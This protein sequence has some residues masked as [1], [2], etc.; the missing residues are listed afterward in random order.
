MKKIFKIYLYLILVLTIDLT[1]F[2]YIEEA[3]AASASF[4][5]SPSS[6]QVSV[7]E[8]ISASVM[9]STDVA[10]NAGEGSVSYPS[11]IL[12]YQS[13]SNSG[14]IFSFWTSGPSG[15]ESGVTFGG[16]LASPGYS[17]SGGRVLTITWKA[18]QNGTATI[19]ITGSKILAN[20]GT[21]TNILSGSSG[22]TVT[23]GGVAKTPSQAT[24]VSSSTH[25]DQNAWYKEKKVDLSW[26]AAA[27][28][29]YSFS[30]DQ[31]P[32][33]TPSVTPVSSKSKSYD[34][35]AE[36]VWYFHIRA[37]FD[38]GFGQTTH[39]KIQ[40]DTTPPEE[41]SISINQ[42]GGISNPT[43]AVNFAA[44]DKLSGI[45]RYEALID[46][47]QPFAITSGDKLPKQKPGDHTV[48]IRAI[49]K[50]G[51][52]RESNGIYHIQ[53]IGPPV[54]LD[55][56]KTVGLL[57]Y[58]TFSG[59]AVPDDTII[60]YLGDK[61]L[62]RFKAGDYKITDVS[63]SLFNIKVEAQ[64]NG[65]IVWQYSIEKALFAGTYYFRIG[66]IDKNGAESE[67]SN[68]LKV[69]VAASTIKLLGRS[70]PILYL[71]IPLVVIIIV[72]LVVIFWLLR[73]IRRF[74]KN[75]GV[76]FGPAWLRVKGVFSRTEVEIDNQ[77][78]EVIPGNN[79]SGGILNKIKNDLKEK[80]HETFQ[81]EE[82]QMNIREDP[83]AN[84]NKV[85]TN[86]LD[87]FS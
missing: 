66:R 20:D 22:G 40:I 45:A 57:E 5:L 16:G 12:E 43:P 64:S 23:V 37:N 52:I 18:K 58:I 14:S 56:S 25:P 32:S 78:E 19:N 67:L 9:V 4:F 7:G 83:K 84:A 29:G 38:S 50:A 10:I 44:N 65:E 79:L 60:I 70:I 71:I 51:N 72:L 77:I 54:I 42:E 24:N 87:K 74:A 85:E 1:V 61:E 31:S 3:K 49:D 11:D 59:R 30:F 62:T 17:G 34:V 46:N 80:V 75:K 53:G 69:S 6:K 21:G 26:S 48:I 41:F 13:V 35:T 2:G 33:T 81:K 27:N 28:Q 82:N 73:K 76:G 47:G 15:S 39:F 55:W 68:P 36:G 63:Q 8:T 86:D